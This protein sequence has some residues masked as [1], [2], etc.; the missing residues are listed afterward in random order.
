MDF[1]TVESTNIPRQNFCDAD[2]GLYKAQVLAL[3]YGLAWGEDIA[4][5]IEPFQRSFIT[6][7]YRSLNVV[8]GAVDNAA[9]RGEIAAALGKNSAEDVPRTW[10]LDCGNSNESGQVLLGSAVTEKQMAYAFP[11]LENQGQFRPLFCAAIPSPSIQHP[12]LLIPLAELDFIH[13]E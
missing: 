10:Y 12:E 11:R 5:I 4:A 8:V 13:L 1:D 3:R 7:D 2:L 9:A 6:K